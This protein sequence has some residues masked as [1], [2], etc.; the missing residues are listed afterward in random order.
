MFAPDFPDIEGHF[1]ELRKLVEGFSEE[2]AFPE[3]GKMVQ[4]RKEICDGK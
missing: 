2:A 4:E 1:I 3:F